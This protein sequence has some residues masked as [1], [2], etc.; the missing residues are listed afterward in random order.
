ML[1]HTCSF[2][3]SSNKALKTGATSGIIQVSSLLWLR[4]INNYQYRYGTDIRT[5]FKTLYNN[6]GILRF[7]R[8]YIPSL[9]V[10]SNCKFAELNGYYYSKHSNFTQNEQLLFISTISSL[11]K[12]S[13][14]PLDTLDVV[15]QVEGKKGVTM[16]KKK[17]KS[18]GYNVLYYGATPWIL[19]NFIGTYVWFNIHNYLDSKYKANYTSGIEFNIKNGLIGLSSSLASDILTNP[20]RI[21]K[22]NKQSN[23]IAVSYMTTIKDIYTNQNYREFFLR[24]LKTRMLIHGIQNVGFV[25]VWKN[26]EKY[27]NIHN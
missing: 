4:T 26:L 20:L 9:I 23:P 1:E 21:L 25:I 5:T 15:L 12:L 11:T 7:Y 27:F 6:G 13:L 16:L 19:N 17:I 22:I 24:G 3:E 10:A 2:I 14:I 18:N 8:G